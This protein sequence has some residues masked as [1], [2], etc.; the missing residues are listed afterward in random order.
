M[1][2]RYSIGH[3]GV[4]SNCV[5]YRVTPKEQSYQ[6]SKAPIMKN[7]GELDFGEIPEPLKFVR[8][9]RKYLL[10]KDDLEVVPYS[11]TFLFLIFLLIYYK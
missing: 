1:L 7:F 5:T 6:F 10:I 3:R 11:L 4:N 9:F 2:S 8:P